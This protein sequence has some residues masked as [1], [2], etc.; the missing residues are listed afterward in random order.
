VCLKSLKTLVV[1]HN[2][3]GMKPN[4]LKSKIIKMLPSLERIDEDMVSEIIPD[5]G[6]DYSEEVGEEQ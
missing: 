4:V 3:F 1:S 5:D 6:S 2:K